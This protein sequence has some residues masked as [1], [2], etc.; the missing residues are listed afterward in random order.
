MNNGVYDYAN[1][2]LLG[3]DPEMVFTEKSH[4]DF[5]EGAKNPVIHNDEDG[6]D[7]DVESWMEEFSDDPA[8]VNLL[9]QVV[10]ATRPNVAWNKTRGSIPIAATTVRELCAR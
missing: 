4:V 6:T 1:K 2:F 10:G 3:F 7:W 9:W 8:M 5:V